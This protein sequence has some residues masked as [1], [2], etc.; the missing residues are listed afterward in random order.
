MKI[1]I[2]ED[3]ELVFNLYK[4]YLEGEGFQIE[5]ALDGN[6]AFHKVSDSKPDLLILDIMMPNKD[7]VE[8]LR[9]IRSKYSKEELPVIILTNL[10]VQE[11]KTEAWGLDIEAYMIKSD[12]TNENLLNQ[13]KKSLKLQ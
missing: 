1:L 5:G 8:A 2:A 10:N 3:D 13:I 7:G 4:R 11:M 9:L 12:I 6:E